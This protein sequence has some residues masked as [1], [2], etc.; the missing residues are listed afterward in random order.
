MR[1]LICLTSI[2]IALGTTAG[3]AYL[4]AHSRALGHEEWRFEERLIAAYADEIAIHSG[5]MVILAIATC[6]GAAASRRAALSTLASTLL[7]SGLVIIAT[8][9]SVRAYIVAPPGSLIWMPKPCVVIFILLWV[10]SLCLLAAMAITV[11]IKR[12]GDKKAVAVGSPGEG[13]QL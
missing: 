5:P 12:S 7:A 10:S 3:V 4:I 11:V 6:V 2:L 9:E 1:L 13:N 8:R